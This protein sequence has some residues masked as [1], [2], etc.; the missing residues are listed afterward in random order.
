[1]SIDKYENFSLKLKHGPYVHSYSRD[2]RNL[3]LGG[4]K[5]H[6][7]LIDWHKPLIKTELFLK[8]KVRDVW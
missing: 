3:L 7:S 2:G 5:G 6:V 4:Q 1:M 8:E